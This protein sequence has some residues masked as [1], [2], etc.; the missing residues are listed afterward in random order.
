MGLRKP[1]NTVG[2]VEKLEENQEVESGIGQVKRSSGD[3]LD[4]S[5]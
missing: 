1:L 2:V 4:A 3:Y 5:R